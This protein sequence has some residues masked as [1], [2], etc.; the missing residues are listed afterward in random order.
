LHLNEGDLLLLKADGSL[1]RPA[2]A[3]TAH[4]AGAPASI[5]CGVPEIIATLRTGQPVLFDDGK[6]ATVVEQEGERE[7]LLRVTRTR[8][9]GAKLGAEKGINLPETSLAL[10]SLSPA[11]LAALDVA[12]AHAEL[13]GLSFTRSEDDVAALQA[14][15]AERGLEHVGIILKIETRAGFE[16]LP[17]ILLRALERPKVAVMIARGDLA[18]E[19]GFERLAEL[20]E[21]ILW[22]CEAARVPVIWAT[23]VLE[24]LVKKGQPTRA[25]I[26]DAAMAERAECVML[27]KGVYIRSAIH[28]LRDVL[29]RM[30]GHQEK[31]RSMLRPLRSPRLEPAHGS[32]D[33]AWPTTDS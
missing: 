8:L 6:I 3:A 15:L 4:D 19:C 18:V 10:P 9:G 28:T 22:L 24:T 7:A 33:T 31:K 23:Q 27:N 29:G 25:E 17:R 14:A 5:A 13:V 2:R 16:A 11:D 30:R 26:T 20:Q 1:G 12:A 21:E 32:E